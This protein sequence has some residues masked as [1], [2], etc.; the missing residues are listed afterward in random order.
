MSLLGNFIWLVTSFYVPIA[1][2]FFGICLFPVLPF[3]WP[4]I[5]YSFLPFGRELVSVSYLEQFSEADSSGPSM[6]DANKTVRI[7]A[8]I[9]WIIPGAILA[10]MHLIAAIVNL[11]ACICIVTIPLA[12]PNMLAH[13]KMIPGAFAPFGKKVI[14]A[15]LSTKLKNL[16]ADEEIEKLKGI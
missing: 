5:R 9:V 12:I 13:L 15:E 4:T 8:N 3:L 10:L 11:G 1:Y 2:L 7:L 14:S 6:K 16:K